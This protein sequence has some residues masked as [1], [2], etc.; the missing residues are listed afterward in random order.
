MTSTERKYAQVEKEAAA[1]SFRVKRFHQFLFGRTFTLVVDNQTL[2][3][4]LNPDRELPSLAAARMQ[5]YALQLATY[6]YKVEL[7]RTDEMRLADMISRLA[8]PDTEEE[9]QAAADEAEYV[10]GGVLFIAKQGPCLTAKDI[11]AATRRDPVLA[12][13]LAAVRSG[14]AGG[15][16]G[17]RAV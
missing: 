14:W 13:A 8:V 2:S 5:Q 17:P 16:S 11:A 3:K 12:L 10:G 7:R 1:V 9:Q 6:R 4:I 15:G